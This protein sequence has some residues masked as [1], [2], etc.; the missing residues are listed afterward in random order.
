[1]RDLEVDIDLIRSWFDE[2][3]GDDVAVLV[4]RASEEAAATW[5]TDLIAGARRCY[6]SDDFL[7]R[8]AAEVEATKAE[9]LAALLPDPG[10]V[11]AGDFGEIV[12]F[13]FLASTEQQ[14]D[15]IGPKKWRLK[16]DRLKPAPYSDVV[17]FVAPNW[18]DPSADDR[19]LCAEVKTKSTDGNSTPI[20]SAI[21]DSEKDRLGRLAKTLAW[22][23]ERALIEDLGTTSLALIERFLK[24]DDHPPAGKKFCAVAVVCTSILDAELADVPE[25]V[26]GDCTVAVIAIPELKERYEEVFAAV[27]GSVGE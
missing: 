2:D 3:E 13:L 24:T 1:M 25:D 23:R 17:Q 5:V 22:L 7:E 12:T 8:R 6:V 9:A 19:L 16:Q 18:P 27:L 26:P 14:A 20:A 10:S 15:V 11:M 4:V 21:A